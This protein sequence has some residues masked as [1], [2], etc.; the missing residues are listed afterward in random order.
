M[1]H[2]QAK[3]TLFSMLYTRGAF[4]KTILAN[5]VSNL[6]YNAFAHCQPT[7]LPTVL[8]TAPQSRNLTQPVL[9]QT[10]W[11]DPV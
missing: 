5:L 2:T 8:G 10:Y 9:V 6:G 7:K 1:T 11:T 3:M 4:P